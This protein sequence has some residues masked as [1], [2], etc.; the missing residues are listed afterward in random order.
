MHSII[1]IDDHPLI[2]R[3]IKDLITIDDSFEFTG[4]ADTGEK[5]IE[6][7]LALQPDIILL[8]LNMEKMNGL[9]TLQAIKATEI[10]AHVVILTVSD[11]EKDIVA[12]LRAGADGYLLKDME[13]EDMLK[14]LHDVIEGHIVLSQKVSEVII[15][16]LHEEAQNKTRQQATLTRRE[17]QIL[18]LISKGLSNRRIAHKLN[19]VEGTVKV[20]VKHLLRKLNLR[21]R[22]EAA[23]WVVEQKTQKKNNRA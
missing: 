16:G 18:S 6:I 1:I 9:E 10:D 4:E 11:N 19:I 3:G 22:V 13:P 20:H 17:Q 7:A 23:L 5:G 21:S 15:Q 12:A 8:D 2:R 14:R